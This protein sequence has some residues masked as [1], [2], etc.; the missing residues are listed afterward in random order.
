MLLFV[1][2]A[3]A[4]Q[5]QA[6]STTFGCDAQHTGLYSATA[7]RLDQIRWT[8]RITS[9][10][11]GWAHYG[12]PLITLANTVIVPVRTTSGFQVSA[13]D[14]ATGRLKYTLTTDYLLPSYGWLPVYQPV[15]AFAPSGT[16]LYYAGAGGTVY[17][18]E[19]SDADSPSAAVQQCFYSNLATYRSN[20]A[21]FNN[22]IYINTPLTADK[23]GDIFFAFRVGGTNPP[24]PFVSTNSGFVR[25]DPDG[26]GTYVLANVAAGNPKIG[27]D[28][29]NCA[30]A[31]SNDGTT[32]YV[33]ARGAVNNGPG[34]TGLTSSIYNYLLGLDTR[35]LV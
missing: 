31:L 27:S 1:L 4:R 11:D 32:L 29:N 7:Q 24:L 14:G 15:L 22:S 2:V 17:Y 30:A 26:N 3:G 19:N 33:V 9:A 8:T 12:A 10:S 28:P 23:K 16:R 21:V 18:V 20:A 34:V 13:F 6:Q 25:I 5:A 35:T